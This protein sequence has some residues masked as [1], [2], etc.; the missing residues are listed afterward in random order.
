MQT[1]CEITVYD[2]PYITLQLSKPFHL[3][4]SFKIS[5]EAAD[6]LNEYADK[7]YDI[8]Y[9]MDA[10]Q[11]HIAPIKGETEWGYNPAY[12]LSARYNLHRNYAEH[13]LKKGDLTNRDINHILAR[14]DAGKKTAFDAA[15]A[16]ELYDE[17]KNNQVDDHVDWDALS[18]QLAN[19]DVLIIT[20]GASIVRKEAE[21]KEFIEGN[22]PITISV[23]FIPEVF[24][25]DF[26]F[27]SN[28]KR[29]S[30]F[31]V[32][33]CKTIITSNITDGEAD[34]KIN[35]NSLSG[36]FDQGCNSFIML[37]KMLKNMKS[38]KIYVAGA[39]GYTEHGK[40]YYSPDM[41]SYTVHG[42][43]FNIAVS[44]AIRKLDINIDYITESAYDMER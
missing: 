41:R 14:F 24:D 15:Y 6:Y 33:P 38:G 12:F 16:D 20:P 4:F 32:H 10:I 5:P 2:I 30:S 22:K 36:A 35:Y 11:D 8:D 37:L 28:N 39:D 7:T 13:Y 1:I 34:F 23:N 9:M 31:D 44:E 43:K 17:Y 18:S 19:K 3:S 42:N 27:F 25:V 26:A 21:I 29:F 40:N